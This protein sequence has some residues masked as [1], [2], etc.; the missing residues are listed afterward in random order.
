M[1]AF[2]TLNPISPQ[3]EAI[4]GLFSG[5]LIILG[6]IFALV[7]VL[8]TF[9]IARY[10][11]RPGAQIPNQISGSHRLEI[12]WTAI[13]ILLLAVMF[14]F[15]AKVMRV[16]LPSGAPGAPDLL[17]TGHQWWW[18]VKYL[19]SGVVTA[20]E[21]HVPVGQ[22][23]LVQLESADV[24]HDFWVPRLGPKLDATPGRSGYVW[25][26]ADRPGVY[27]GACAEFCGAEHA[28]MRFEVVAQPQPEFAAWEQ[29]QLAVPPAPAS[30][31]GLAGMKLFVGR[32]CVNC[33]SFDGIST[34][35]HV[36]PD[37]THLADRHMLAGGAAV[38][39]PSTLAQWLKDPESIK[40]GS[41]M[42]NFQLSD[43]EV[44]QLVAYLE[45]TKWKA[46]K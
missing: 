45:S 15:T 27:L 28:W 34:D 20:N 1:T 29:A 35:R 44:N 17:I 37:L 43:A 33:H 10:R 18:E 19:K 23:M 4:A 21:V 42:P 8:V 24:I 41:N 2:D 30:A 6:A 46:M 9:A 36:G 12:V 39:T 14:G 25:L 26:E 11:E 38:N 22:R 13:P 32:T 7:A 16:S 3:A 40:P 5:V 31:Q